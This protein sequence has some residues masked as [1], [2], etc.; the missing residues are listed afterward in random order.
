MT[1]QAELDFAEETWA[2]AR[3]AKSGITGEASHARAPAPQT[4]PEAPQLAPAPDA[5]REGDAKP[6]R[7]RYG[8]GLRRALLGG[9]AAIGLLAAAYVYWDYTSHF[10]STDDAFI[11]SRQFAI[12]PKV[13]GYIT[14]VPVT[15][16]QHVA[17]GDVIA[18]IDDR[19]YQAALAQ[20]DGQVDA[21]E[22]GIAN[23]DA[24]L[25]VQQAQIAANQ[26]GVNQVEAN[27]VFARQQ[28]ERAQALL[29]KGAGSLQTAQQNESQL[30][31]QEASL[32]TA[33]AT[34][35]VGQ[36]QVEALKAQRATALATLAQAK[37]QREQAALNLANTVIRAAQPG[38]VV[39]LSG[40]VGEFVQA[41]TS[42]A[43][44]VPDETWVVANFKESQL[45]AMRP[46]EASTLSI[47]AYPERTL[48]GH[49]ASIQPGSGTAFSLLPT[50][51]ATGN[52]VKVVQRVPVKIIIDDLPHDVTLGPGMSVVPTVRVDPSRS[53][54]ERLRNW[55]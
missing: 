17:P 44:F 9:A 39:K 19:D 47:D 24:Q 51:N 28:A 2:D 48:H 50:E 5:A 4:L 10:Q 32:N 38:R 8:R 7:Q 13:A 30:R 33:R 3:F 12:A 21:A 40:A 31:A 41:G 45:D 25:K 36:R 42:I 49:V 1:L 16:D 29:D 27:L 46:G 35:N 14:A 6:K 34:L 55:L 15:D 20:A 23:I 43:M 26:A 53:M 18:R 52:Y 11:A 37:A 54:F 22:A